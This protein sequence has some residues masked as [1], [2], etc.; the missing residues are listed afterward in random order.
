MA[1]A[2]QA[3]ER[4]IGSEITEIGTSDYIEPSRPL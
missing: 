2:E 1:E 3:R 4:V